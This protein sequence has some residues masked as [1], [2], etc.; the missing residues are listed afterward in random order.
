MDLFSW[1]TGL[2]VAGT[3]T[4]TFNKDSLWFIVLT[5]IWICIAFSLK[6]HKGLSLKYRIVCFVLLAGWC[7]AFYQIIFNTD[8][9][10]KND[11]KVNQFNPNWTYKKTVMRCLLQRL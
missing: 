5:M 4:V 7:T 1:K 9:L 11:I 2:A 6:G 8:I 10:L 3:Y